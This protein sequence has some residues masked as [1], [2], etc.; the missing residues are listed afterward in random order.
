MKECK[1]TYVNEFVATIHQAFYHAFH[2]QTL[3]RTGPVWLTARLG[4][5]HP[6][7]P[8][9]KRIST[10]A[11]KAPGAGPEG[12]KVCGVE[13]PQG[14][15]KAHWTDG[16][17]QTDRPVDCARRVQGAGHSHA[18]PRIAQETLPA[19]GGAQDRGAGRG[20]RGRDRTDENPAEV[21]RG[22]VPPSRAGPEAAP[23]QLAGVWAPAQLGSVCARPRVGAG[24]GCPGEG[25]GEGVPRRAGTQE[26][27][28]GQEW[29]QAAGPSDSA[30][31]S[32]FGFSLPGGESTASSF[33]AWTPSPSQPGLA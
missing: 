13:H 20:R 2:L 28:R 22:A 33:P 30:A 23:P 21:R 14:G 11:K 9:P 31:R 3:A 26:V 18:Q 15:G 5:G 1:L 27:G 10:K 4:R 12:G 16:A 6:Q 19:Q 32:D 17:G 25:T 24:S 7:V 29:A 8:S